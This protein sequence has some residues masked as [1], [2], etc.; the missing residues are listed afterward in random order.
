MRLAFNRACVASVL[1]LVRFAVKYPLIEGAVDETWYFFSLGLIRYAVSHRH[2]ARRK[3]C[4]HQPNMNIPFI[5]QDINAD[6]YGFNDC[7]TAEVTCGIVCGCL[8]AFPAFIRHVFDIMN[9]VTKASHDPSRPTF[10]SLRPKPR[11]P[12]VLTPPERLTVLSPSSRDSTFYKSRKLI[13]PV[14]TGWKDGKGGRRDQWQELSELEYVAGDDKRYSAK[15]SSMVE[16]QPPQPI[17]KRER[18]K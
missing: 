1:R 2:S 7:S 17:L 11:L 4:A 14:T 6:I 18:L 15:E 3:W 10:A 8:P 13:S 9:R 16:P 5:E 12:K